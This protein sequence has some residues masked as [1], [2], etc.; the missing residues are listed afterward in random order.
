M[1]EGFVTRTYPWVGLRGQERC[2]NDATQGFVLS[3]RLG[4]GAFKGVDKEKNMDS[5]NSMESGTY[6]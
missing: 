3:T 6:R 4:G 2:I 5:P 1:E